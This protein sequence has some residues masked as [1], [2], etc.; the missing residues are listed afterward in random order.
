[1]IDAE[2]VFEPIQT[3]VLQSLQKLVAK[4]VEHDQR[5]DSLESRITA[6]AAD[7]KVIS[8]QFNDVG[9]MAI[10]DSE[11]I[12]DLEGRVNDLESGVH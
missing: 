4:S 2:R 11:R 7:L 10:K 9:I 8:G 1:M 12:D 6:V 3:E 5:F